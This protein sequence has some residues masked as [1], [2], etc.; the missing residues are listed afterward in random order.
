VKAASAFIQAH[1][2]APA[3]PRASWPCRC[4]RH[5]ALGAQLVKLHYFAGLT[6]ARGRYAVG[7]L[8]ALR[9]HDLITEIVP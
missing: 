2:A 7:R 4:A 1:R 9:D 5:D 8:E 3:T 6:T